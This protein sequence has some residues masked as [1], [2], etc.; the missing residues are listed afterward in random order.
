MADESAQKPASE[1]E[2]ENKN[3]ELHAKFEN[4]LRKVD[5]MEKSQQHPSGVPGGQVFGVQ[6]QPN[7]PWGRPPAFSGPGPGPGHFFHGQ[8]MSL[9]APYGGFGPGMNTPPFNGYPGGQQMHQNASDSSGGDG[10]GGH[11]GSF[12]MQGG[13]GFGDGGVGGFGSPP[14]NFMPGWGFASN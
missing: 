14:G 12:F 1:L 10:Q 11:A 8:G 7:F 2:I 13:G 3:Q 4:L 5:A 9:H 6:Q